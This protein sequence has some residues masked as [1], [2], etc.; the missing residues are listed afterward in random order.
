MQPIVRRWIIAAVVTVAT[1]AGV[2]ACVSDHIIYKSTQFPAPPSGAAD[3]VGYA[4]VSAK[5]TVCGNCHIDRQTEWLAT[6]HASAWADLIATGENPAPC[7]MCHTVNNNGNQPAGA[8]TAVGYRSTLAARYQDVQCESCHGPGL[9]HVTSPSITN[10]PLASL[11]VGSVATTIKACGQCHHGAHEP[12][13]DEWSM[14]RH[15]TVP[16]W[17]T[18]AHPEANPACQSCHTGQGALLA[19]GVS[20]NYKEAGFAGGDTLNITCGVCHDPHPIN[21][22]PA[23]LRFPD[24]VP[25]V[26]TNL[27]MKCHQNGSGLDP[28]T[29]KYGPHSPEGPLLLGIAGWWP[30]NL[31]V[32]GGLDTIVSTH[33]TTANPRLCA[34]CHVNPFTVTDSSGKFVLSVTGH[35]FE[36]APCVN[37]QGIPTGDTI[38][39]TSQRSFA[40]CAASGCHG[41]AAAA[42]SAFTS[43]QALVASL[44]TTLR[45]QLTTVL[46]ATPAETASANTTF[47][48]AQGSLFNA[49]LAEFRGSFV[50]NPF[51]IQALLTASIEEMTAQ[52]GVMAARVRS[53]PEIMARYRA[54]KLHH[55]APAGIPRVSPTII[56][57]GQR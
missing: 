41:N 2:V 18:G 51:L 26:Q 31:Q 19:W 29:V 15:A 4:E 5:M 47:T 25:D 8:D 1:V 48:V 38:C 13:E 24:S 49:K 6:K 17:K 45:A 39:V 30:P 9:T 3:Y 12:F 11:D 37:S 28:E 40:A 16:V 22:Y 27:C 57:L 32:A 50:H 35:L 10:R 52:Y 14:S 33:G 42:A 43:E 54:Y 21:L 56:R 34:T 23:Q 20:T 55:L 7:A 44:D 36:A 53:L 46:T